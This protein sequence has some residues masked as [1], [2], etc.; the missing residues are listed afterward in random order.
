[1]LRKSMN[2][3]W[4]VKSSPATNNQR[5]NGPDKHNE[6]RHEQHAKGS[7]TNIRS[8][9]PPQT[10]SLLAIGNALMDDSED[11]P[12]PVTGSRSRQIDGDDTLNKASA[13]KKPNIPNKNNPKP[14]ERQII[15]V[16]ITNQWIVQTHRT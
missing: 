8:F 14:T 1:M 10:A 6:H 11:T 4:K 13:P 5:T 12:A 9:Q 2:M 15:P 16:N 3:K 7:Q